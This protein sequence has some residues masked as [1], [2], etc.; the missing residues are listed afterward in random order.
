MT[1]P[2]DEGIRAAKDD[3]RKAAAGKITKRAIRVDE[4][5]PHIICGCGERIPVPV[6]TG[7]PMTY[8][9]GQCGTEYDSRGWILKENFVQNAANS[10]TKQG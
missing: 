2:A 3:A 9:C 7:M 10:L 1:T 5:G 4:Q 8:Q 6:I